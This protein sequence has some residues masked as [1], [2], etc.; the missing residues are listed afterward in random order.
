M[1]GEIVGEEMRLNKLGE[2][3]Q[4]EWFRTAEIREDVEL[5]SFVVM[6]NHIHGIIVLIESGRGTL[7]RAPTKEQFGKP[8]SGSI[9]TIVRL[10]KSCVT[11]RINLL[12]NT[13]RQPI[14]Q[15]NYYEHIIRDDK[16]LYNAREYIANNPVKW[17]FEKEIPDNL[18]GILT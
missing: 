6:P 11:K 17:L 3:V 1:F 15:R 14:W 12:R 8:T 5:D 7:R 9:P 16:D 13:Q 10:F 18:I 4:E 2:I